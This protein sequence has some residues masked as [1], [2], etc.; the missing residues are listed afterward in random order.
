MLRGSIIIFTGLLSVA[1]LRSVLQPFRWLGMA[2]VVVGLLV[3]GLADFAFGSKSVDDVNGVI[4]GVF[5]RR[6][7][8]KRRAIFR[9][10]VDRNG[11]DNRCD[12]C[13]LRTKVHW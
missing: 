8:L 10:S 5:Q 2:F 9:R 4:T 1:F 6:K 3:V 13:C 12:S 11:T 7:L